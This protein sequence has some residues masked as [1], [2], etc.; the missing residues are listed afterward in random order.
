M[1]ELLERYVDLTRGLALGSGPWM[2]FNATLATIPAVLAVV[3]FHRRVRRGWTWWAGVVAFVLFLP[4]APYVMTDLIHLR[5]MIDEH[6]DTPVSAVLPLVAL[7]G[8]ALWGLSAYAVALAQVDRLLAREGWSRARLPIR[9]S[10]HLLCGFGI[11]LGR[12]PR[13]HSWYVLTRPAS[14]VDGLVGVLHPLVVPLT[15]GLALAAAMGVWVVT[16]LAR[17]LAERGR[18][19]LDAAARRI[20]PAVG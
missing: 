11:V 10:L 20:G 1:V 4:N 15:V 6:S 12:L 8:L 14:A 16:V 5:W 19:L 17:A 9:T 7:A 2:A 13:L 18:E 3:L